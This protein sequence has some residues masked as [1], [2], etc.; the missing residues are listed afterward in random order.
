MLHFFKNHSQGFCRALSC[1]RLNWSIV[2]LT[3]LI[4]GGCSTQQSGTEF[5]QPLL[6]QSG[7]DVMWMP[8]SNNL[9]T[10]MLEIAKVNETDVVYDLGS[11]DGKIPIE[12][13]RR[14]GARAVGIEF[15]PD[16]AALARRHA[17]QA[18][19]SD[20][21]TIVTGDIFEEDFSNATVVT[22]YLLT[23]LN[24][25]L[26]PSLLSMKP[27][28]RIVSN[29]FL[30]GS[31]EPDENIIADG[32][33]SGYLWIVPAKVDG[34]WSF[35]GLPGW[36]EAKIKLTQKSQ[37]FDGDLIFEDSLKQ[38]IEGRLRGAQLTFDYQDRDNQRLSFDGIVSGNRIHGTIKQIPGSVI[39][40]TKVQ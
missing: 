14:Y 4:A 13:A 21:V 34:N 26:K 1:R 35:S 5:Y 8:T 17:Q 28:T 40:A 32:D 25:K 31:W 10:E 7:K 38:R 30:M 6:A 37:K 2:L 15:N 27:G 22:L 12:A 11:G 16:L 3:G 9:V 24:I 18:G 29:T 39:T 20:R 36:P 23:K 19:V 33:V